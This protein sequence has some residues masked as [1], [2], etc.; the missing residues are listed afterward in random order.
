MDKVIDPGEEERGTGTGGMTGGW[1]GAGI[2]KEG[3]KASPETT[4]GTILGG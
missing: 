3:I 2:V 1:K 4:E